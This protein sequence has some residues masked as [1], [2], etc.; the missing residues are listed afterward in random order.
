MPDSP[1]INSVFLYHSMLYGGEPAKTVTSKLPSVA[2]THDSLKISKST[3]NTSI[4]LAIMFLSVP[5]VTVSGLLV[6]EASPLQLSKLH[7]LAG[8]ASKTTSEPS[9]KIFSLGLRVII[10]DPTIEVAKTTSVETVQ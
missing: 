1:T 9:S 10:P 8:T 4:K 7:P 2:S 6:P 5:I 3:L